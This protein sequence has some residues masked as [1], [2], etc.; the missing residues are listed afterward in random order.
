MV[1]DSLCAGGL[2][3]GPGAVAVGL[4][5]QGEPAGLPPAGHARP[6]VQG[7]R[8]SKG[9]P[10]PEPGNPTSSVTRPLAV[11]FGGMSF[12][13]PLAYYLENKD[14]KERAA[15]GGV[16]EPLLVQPGEVRATWSRAGAGQGRP[17]HARRVGGLPRHAC[18]PSALER[19]CARFAPFPF[20]PA[21]P[22]PNPPPH[23]PAATQVAPNAQ[24]RDGLLANLPIAIPTFFD[25]I[26]TILMNI[27]LLWV[28][29]SVYQM[30]RGA[31]M[32]F[33]ALFSVVFLKR[34]CVPSAAWL[35]VAG[36][37]R[38]GKGEDAPE[39]TRSRRDD[40]PAPR[41]RARSPRPQRP[42]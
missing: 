35:A 34:T 37:G 38:G 25:L 27:G 36:E 12:C 8:G 6:H 1:H 2:A 11:M 5:G 24:P 16:S 3:E 18:S 20:D 42:A 14:R 30:M 9:P 32:L 19:R 22:P 26:A 7:V 40:R 29:A 17:R 31:E 15:E 21:P 41:S 10:A 4:Q 33:A 23:P 39:C 13:L 28:T